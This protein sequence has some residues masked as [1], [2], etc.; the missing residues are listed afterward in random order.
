[1]KKNRG[2]PTLVFNVQI[3]EREKPEKIE[4]GLPLAPKPK[5]V[6]QREGMLKRQARG[7]PRSNARSIVQTIKDYEGKIDW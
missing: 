5:V 6:R 3:I 7:I 4:E 2:I 1:M